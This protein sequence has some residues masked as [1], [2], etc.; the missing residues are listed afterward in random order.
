[1]NILGVKE[2]TL[3]VPTCLLRSASHRRVF[4]HSHQLKSSTATATSTYRIWTEPTIFKIEMA[5]RI[6][7]F[8]AIKQPLIIQKTLI[9]NKCTRSFFFNCNTLHVSTLLRHLQGQLSV[10]VTLRLHFSVE[11]ECAVDCVLC[12]FWR[13][14]LSV[15][16]AC[17]RELLQKQHSTQST[18]HSRSTEK[19][20][21]SVTTTE[22]CP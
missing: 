1:V 8:F 19:C 12:C 14:E 3:I 13:R 5:H 20:N 7:I 21:L 6:S 15:V 17:K 4:S 16:P 11:R 10:V 2:G 9:T 18:A 22:S